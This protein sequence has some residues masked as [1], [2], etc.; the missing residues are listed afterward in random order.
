M[1][2]I[3][4]DLRGDDAVGGEVARRLIRSACR[5]RSPRLQGFDG[6]SGP[7]KLTRAIAQFLGE[8]AASSHIV[9][10]DAADLGVKPGAIRLLAPQDLA[11]VSFSTHQLPLA[12][13]VQYLEGRLGCG[14]TILA[15]QPRSLEFGAPMSRD[16]ERA[17][18]RLVAALQSAAPAARRRGAPS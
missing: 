4:S 1:L 8:E 18:A 7:G 11:G 2:G 16:L 12:V 6:G 10:V 5:S 3:G 15:V 14:V 13:T 9:L 17:A